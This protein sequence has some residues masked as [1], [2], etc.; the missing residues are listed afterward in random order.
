MSDHARDYSLGTLDPA[1]L[2][3]NMLRVSSDLQPP[4]R[5]LTIDSETTD[6][7][8]SKGVIWQVGYCVYE[9]GVP[10]AG[11]EKGRNW[12]VKRPEVALLANT[13]EIGRRAAKYAKQFELSEHDANVVATE[14]YLAEVAEF[15]REPADVFGDLA[16]LASETLRAGYPVVGQNMV[17]FDFPFFEMEFARYSLGFKFPEEGLIDVGMHIKAAKLGRRIMERETARAFA[18][19]IAEKRARGVYYAIEKFC[20]PY[21]DMKRRYGINT[22]E[23]HNAGYDCYL[24]SLVLLDLLADARAGG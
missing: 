16:A 9:N 1:T 8:P 2:R 19:S 22:D 14:D 13:Y 4:G 20:I 6:V 12:W 17:K 11:H 15:G 10:L 18:A 7:E 23:T 24:T 5:F 3:H 21:W